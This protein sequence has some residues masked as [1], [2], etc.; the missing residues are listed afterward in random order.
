MTLF[1]GSRSAQIPADEQKEDERYLLR[2]ENQAEV[3]LRACEIEDGER[4]RHRSDGAACERDR[5]T[6]EEKAELALAQR[7]PAPH[8]S[9]VSQ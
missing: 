6:G 7:R 4:E 1:R 3:G 5:A 2:G 8:H 9:R